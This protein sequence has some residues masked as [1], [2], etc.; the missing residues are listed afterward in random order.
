KV[1]AWKVSP[2]PEEG[3]PFCAPI[4]AS[5]IHDDGARLDRA[6]YHDLGLEVEVAV[7]LGRDLPAVEGGYRGRDM[8]AAI[9]SV[10]VAFELVASRF[11]DRATMPRVATFA[12]LQSNGAVVMGAPVSPE[13]VA[14]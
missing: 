3:E 4:L 5:D 1:G 12:D 14:D 6:A 9:A 13:A 2:M 8:A 10:H 11:T 7:T